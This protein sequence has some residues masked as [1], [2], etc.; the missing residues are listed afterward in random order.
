MSDQSVADTGSGDQGD[1]ISTR[2]IDREV[3]IEFSEELVNEG[4]SLSEEL[5]GNLI[6]AGPSDGFEETASDENFDIS[7]S[8]I[9]SNSANTSIHLENVDIVMELA[10]MSLK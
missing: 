7:P 3:I 5:N 6:V 8:N 9:K 1:S 4:C 2:T 10:V